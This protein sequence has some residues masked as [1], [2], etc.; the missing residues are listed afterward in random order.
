[1]L[2][3]N[4]FWKK[5]PDINCF[6]PTDYDL[7]AWLCMITYFSKCI[8]FVVSLPLNV[9]FFMLN[10]IYYIFT[11]INFCT[12][13]FI[14]STVKV[15]LKPY[16]FS[17]N[18]CQTVFLHVIFSGH[19]KVFRVHLFTGVLYPKSII[20]SR[21]CKCHLFLTCTLYLL[22]D[23]FHEIFLRTFKCRLFFTCILSLNIT[24]HYVFVYKT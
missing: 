21:A 14:T 23:L 12:F 24:Y 10:C 19:L 5:N 13:Y 11:L 1:M 20:V 4:E 8:L 9:Y 17:L 3:D 16:F 6:T 22:Y 18:S 7:D 15:M 2:M